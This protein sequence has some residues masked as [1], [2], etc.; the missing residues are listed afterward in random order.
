MVTG[1]MNFTNNPCATT[2]ALSGTITVSSVILTATEGSQSV[3]FTGTVNGAFTAMSG[4]Y[5]FPIGG[6]NGGD[7]GA[8]AA[9][10][11]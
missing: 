1:T 2:A 4:N 3:S 7:F 8:W 10:K 11:S 5:T 6:C 9:S